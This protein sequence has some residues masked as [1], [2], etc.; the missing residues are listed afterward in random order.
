M[1]ARFKAQ[2]VDVH[3]YKTIYDNDP[4][5]KPNN[6]LYIEL[7]FYFGT[8]DMVSFGAVKTYRAKGEMIAKVYDLVSN[9]TKDLLAACDDIMDSFTT[10]TDT[11]VRFF[12]PYLEHIGRDGGYE[13]KNVHCPFEID[14]NI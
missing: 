6:E 12:T 8:R 13:Q 14:D 10:I 11:G 7:V 5:A 1:R 4:T 3:A 2:V 9:G